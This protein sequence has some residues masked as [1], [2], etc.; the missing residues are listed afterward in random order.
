MD[1]RLLILV[2]LLIILIIILIIM[3]ILSFLNKSKSNVAGKPNVV[4]LVSHPG[5]TGKYQDAANAATEM[6]KLE[7]ENLNDYYVE[8]D[9]SGSLSNDSSLIVLNL[10]HK[11]E[12]NYKGMGSVSGRSRNIIYDTNQN[13]IIK[14]I[15]WK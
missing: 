1:K 9:K 12:L 15:F 10:W 8:I 14:Q 6:L 7:K 3:G 4:P 2:V 13:K 5:F 11:E